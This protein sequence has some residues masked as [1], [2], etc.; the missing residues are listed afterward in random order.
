[1]FIYAVVLKMYGKMG[2]IFY[3]IYV[4]Y[5]FKM[6]CFTLKHYYYFHWTL[7]YM[8]YDH[9]EHYN[10]KSISAKDIQVYKLMKFWVI[11]S[12]YEEA[13]FNGLFP[14]SSTRGQIQWLFPFNNKRVSCRHF[15]C[16]WRHHLHIFG[17][18]H[19]VIDCV[20][21]CV[22]DGKRSIY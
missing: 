1:M 5:N 13:K 20:C 11:I 10:D 6:K 18:S 14:F 4:Y 22:C 9:K 12:L 21:V 19:Q 15:S 7:L 2:F 16:S 17:E 8:F 3:I